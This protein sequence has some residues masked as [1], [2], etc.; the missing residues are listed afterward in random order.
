MSQHVVHT[1][2]RA[3][4]GRVALVTGST[5]GIGAG[6]ADALAAAGAHAVLHGVLAPGQSRDELKR[7]IEQ[8]HGVKVER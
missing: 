8:R 6:I 4:A 7:S 3:L 5:S 2:V 1:A